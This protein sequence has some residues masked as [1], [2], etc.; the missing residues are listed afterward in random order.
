MSSMRDQLLKAGLVTEEQVKQAETAPKKKPHKRRVEQGAGAQ[1][2]SKP[3]KA[4]KAEPASDLEAFYRQREATDKAEQAAADAARKEAARI[5]KANRAKIGKLIREN[6]LNEDAAE[7]RFNFVVGSSVKYV[8]VT[9][10]QQELLA[11]GKLSIVFMGEK[12][13]VIKPEI[14]AEITAIDPARIVITM[15]E[16]S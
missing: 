4:R 6:A 1:K 2:K 15:S 12:R 7:I 13:C 16:E 14:A 5:R 10:A 9:E 8:F 11:E 3:K